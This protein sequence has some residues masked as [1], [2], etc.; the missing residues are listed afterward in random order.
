[1]IGI[2][3]V[4]LRDPRLKNRDER[5]LRLIS[6]PEDLYPES[7]NCFWWLWTAKEAVFKAQRIPNRSFAPKSIPIQIQISSEKILFRSQ[8]FKGEIIEQEDLIIAICGKASIEVY[9]QY[10]RQNTSNASV[11]VRNQIDM[12]LSAIGCQLTVNTDTSGLPAISG[13]IPV[14]IS[15]HAGYTA[16]AIPK[17]ALHHLPSV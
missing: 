1:M 10:N 3:L 13:D 7:P 8:D 9:W 14:A 2:D 16:F 17:T 11:D 15:H 6:H 12:Y 4:N 5:S